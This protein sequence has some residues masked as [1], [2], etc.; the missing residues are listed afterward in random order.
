MQV[1]EFRALPSGPSLYWARDYA[2]QVT[3]LA[4]PPLR[5]GSV[6]TAGR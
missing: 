6:K 3:R 1:K 2:A 5:A 4:V